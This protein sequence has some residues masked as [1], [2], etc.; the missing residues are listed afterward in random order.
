MLILIFYE[1]EFTAAYIVYRY[2]SFSITIG[3]EGGCFSLHETSAFLLFPPNAVEE[4]VTLKCSRVKHKECRVKPSD[5][6]AFVSRIL[7]VRPEGVMFKKPVTVFLSH[8]LDEDQDFLYF[9]ELIVKNLS[10]TGC[11][12]LK[13]ERISSIEGTD[14]FKQCY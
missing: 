11:Q 3:Q 13:T 14:N 6:E 9:Y 7:K 4:E 8:S 2:C 5:G 1:P 12:E 10:P